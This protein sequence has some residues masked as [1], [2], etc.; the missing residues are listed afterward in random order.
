MTSAS[1]LPKRVSRV[2]RGVARDLWKVVAGDPNSIRN[3]TLAR[4]LDTI[5][6]NERK[7][8]ASLRRVLDVQV[9]TAVIGICPC[10]LRPECDPECIGASGSRVRP[11]K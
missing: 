1:T 8:S 11:L 4:G 5:Y 9:M 6:Q 3:S 10:N 2:E 7:P